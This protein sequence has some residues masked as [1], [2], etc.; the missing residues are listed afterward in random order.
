[1][2]QKHSQVIII[3]III[4]IIQCNAVYW[5]AGSSERLPIIKSTQDHECKKAT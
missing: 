1:M 2:V 5:R 3:I 4:I